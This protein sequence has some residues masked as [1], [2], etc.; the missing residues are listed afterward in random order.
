MGDSK[1]K[2]DKAE[3][4]KKKVKTNENLKSEQK[5]KVPK[6]DYKKT[7]KK[8][9]EQIANLKQSNI[10]LEAENQK[11]LIDFQMQAKKFQSKAQ[12]QI[13]ARNLELLNKYEKDK[14][15]IKKFGSQKLIESIIE[16][17][18]NIEQAV[19]AGKN[20]EGVAAYVMG[21]EMLLNQLYSQLSDFGITTI[22]PKVNDEFD[23]EEHFAMKVESGGKENTIKEVKKKGFKLHERIIKPATVIVFKD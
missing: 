23:P 12:E 8:L 21:F 19:Q 6:P 9:E 7:I 14:N 5:N 16:P 1:E 15:E 11:N 18:L 22:I 2:K 3:N 17:I 4:K 10:N 13:N 20:Q